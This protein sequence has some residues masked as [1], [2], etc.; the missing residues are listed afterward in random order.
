MLFFYVKHGGQQKQNMEVARWSNIHG[1]G[2]FENKH[3]VG[4]LSNRKW[5]RKVQWTEYINERMTTTMLTINKKKIVQSSVHFPHREYADHHV[6]KM[7]RCIEHYTK[8]RKHTTI[9][10]VEL[11]PGIGTEHLNVWTAHTQRVE[12]TWR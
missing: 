1:A 9:I 7:Y 10:A 2:G 6:G 3:G 11:G 4:I 8:C 5:K 12:Q